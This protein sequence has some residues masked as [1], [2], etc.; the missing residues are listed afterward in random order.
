MIGGSEYSFL[1]PD[2][3]DKLFD[4]LVLLYTKLVELG[5]EY[6]NGA[7]YLADVEERDV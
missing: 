1:K 3:T 4:D 6:R 2:I 5:M 7:V